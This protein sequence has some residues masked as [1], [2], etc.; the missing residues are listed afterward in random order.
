MPFQKLL[1]M[2]KKKVKAFVL[3]SHET[4]TGPWA[5]VWEM[6]IEFMRKKFL[7]CLV[8]SD[9]MKILL[10]YVKYLNLKKELEIL[11]HYFNNLHFFR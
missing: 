5:S 10:F 3:T 6:L 1:L 7:F 8:L 2:K 4:L 11:L 9:F